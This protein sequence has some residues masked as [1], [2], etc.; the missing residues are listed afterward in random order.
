[1]APPQP[2][3]NQIEHVARTAYGRL[4][5]ILARETGDIAT[6]EDVLADAFTRALTTWADKG[7]PDNPESWLLT[8]ARNR[9]RDRLRSSHHRTSLAGD[10]LEEME[11]R[12]DAAIA[13]TM[14]RLTTSD[15]PDERLKLMLVCAH[16]AIDE[17]MH[18]P[19]MLQ[20]VLGL[21]AKAIA[22]AFAVPSATMAQRLVRTKAK[23]KQA[24]IPFAV[25]ESHVLSERL[26]AVLEAIYGAFAADWQLTGDAAG[27]G[28]A[29]GASDLA[30]E[31]LFLADL[32]VGLMPDHA[33][34]LGLA[35]LLWFGHSRS[36]TRIDCDGCLVPLDEQPAESWDKTALSRARALLRR[37]SGHGKLGRYQIEA[38]IQSVHADRLETD[39]VNWTA[40]VQLYEGLMHLAPT[41][42]AAVARA[43]AVGRA[44]GPS[45][46]LSALDQV[47]PADAEAFQPAW[48]VRAH[49]LAERGDGEAAHRAYQ[50]AIDLTT[51]LAQRR[52]L[53]Q[54]Q[55]VRSAGRK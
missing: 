38:A 46:G 48:A 17:R 5:A 21:D 36:G 14:T 19:L 47:A 40:I 30:R 7:P 37:A 42:G 13:S 39:R 52:F 4:L 6:A 29:H 3:T 55:R 51:N 35:A 43:A 41:L 49:L 44:Y 25:P 8:A 33:E 26:D 9:N 28:D 23:I 11:S 10:T 24:A 34:T 22:T 32:M 45:A 50:R 12:A 2:V 27:A 1:M 53:T 15:L 18:T 20:T 54:R 31:A 16:P